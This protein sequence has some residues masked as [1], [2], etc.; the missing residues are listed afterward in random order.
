MTVITF[1]SRNCGE[2]T[3]PPILVKRANRT[4][5]RIA[6][7]ASA[8]LRTQNSVALRDLGAALDRAAHHDCIPHYGDNSHLVRIMQQLGWRKDGYVGEG[9]GRSPLYRRVATAARTA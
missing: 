1:K 2:T 4:S 9:A 5:A 7:Y 8:L 6:L 3:F